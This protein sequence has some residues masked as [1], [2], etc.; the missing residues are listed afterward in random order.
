MCGWVFVWGLGGSGSHDEKERDETPC[1]CRIAML[2]QCPHHTQEQADTT[3]FCTLH[4]KQRVVSSFHYPSSLPGRGSIIITCPPA[5][6]LLASSPCSCLSPS[7]PPHHDRRPRACRADGA[8]GPRHLL[9]ASVR[10]WGGNA[11][12]LSYFCL[13][14][15]HTTSTPAPWAMMML[16]LASPYTHE[17][18]Q[19]I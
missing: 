11:S 7:P 18:V 8:V 2:C 6:L 14:S 19:S 4:T 9:L 13:H 12:P 16:R 3:H 1:K 10:G 17:L 15:T 5:Q